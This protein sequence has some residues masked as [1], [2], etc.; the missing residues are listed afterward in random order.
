M[1][2]NVRIEHCDSAEAALQRKSYWDTLG[3][4]D[5]AL[6]SEQ[7]TIISANITTQNGTAQEGPP[8]FP[9][10]ANPGIFVIAI[11]KGRS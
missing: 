1:S 10:G 8:N 7:A 2:A 3:G 6:V 4:W 11:A 5:V 9:F